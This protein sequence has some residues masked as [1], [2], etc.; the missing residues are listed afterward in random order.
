MFDKAW[1]PVA[2]LLDLEVTLLPLHGLF[3]HPLSPASIF[4]RN[5]MHTME[6]R[7]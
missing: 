2:S 6:I 3:P 4:Y 7:V 1:L 5:G